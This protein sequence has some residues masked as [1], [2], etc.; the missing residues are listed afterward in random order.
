MLWHGGK[1]FSAAWCLP[2]PCVQYLRI[3]KYYDTLVASGHDAASLARLG[4]AELAALGLPLG[5]S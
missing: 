3:D 5:T 4:D 2:L 1:H